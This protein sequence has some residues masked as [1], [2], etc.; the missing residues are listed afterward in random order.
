[1]GYLV[2]IYDFS[3]YVLFFKFHQP[4][5]LWGGPKIRKSI[6]KKDIP[7]KDWQYPGTKADGGNCIYKQLSC[8]QKLLCARHSG[9][10][11][12]KPHYF[13]E[14]FTGKLRHPNF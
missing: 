5:L 14:V 10:R 7:K 13:L 6:L 1:M 9:Q 2:Q 4:K 12:S 8:T 11:P 3:M